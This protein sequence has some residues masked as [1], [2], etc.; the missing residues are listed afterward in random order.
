MSNCRSHSQILWP[1]PLDDARTLRA[2]GESKRN[3]EMDKSIDDNTDTGDT[4]AGNAA[5]L[6]TITICTAIFPAWKF[7]S[8]K[9]YLRIPRIP[10]LFGTRREPAAIDAN[11]YVGVHKVVDAAP[12]DGCHRR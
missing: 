10:R 5:A 2:G 3:E 8:G 7:L 4:T 11:P 6:L 9:I 1:R 12:Y